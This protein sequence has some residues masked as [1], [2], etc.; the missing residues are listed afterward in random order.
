[1]VSEPYRCRPKDLERFKL[2]TTN[3][4]WKYII[5]IAKT[6]QLSF[7]HSNSILDM[8]SCQH[9]NFQR[10]FQ[11]YVPIKFFKVSPTLAEC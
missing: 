7:E 6:F 8:S 5:F 11:L 1:M 9:K 3:R 10:V 2:E 4:N